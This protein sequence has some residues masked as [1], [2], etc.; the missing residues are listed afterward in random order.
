MDDDPPRRGRRAGTE[1]AARAQREGWLERTGQR[2][3]LG[4]RALALGG[5]A[6]VGTGTGAT[7]GTGAGGTVGTGTAGT[8]PSYINRF[9]A[10]STT[11]TTRLHPVRS[12]SSRATVRT[13]SSQAS[14]SDRLSSCDIAARTPPHP[15]W[16]Q[17]MTSSTFRTSIAYCAT[18][19]RLLSV[20]TTTFAML[21]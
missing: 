1:L 14:T 17:T 4:P 7:V 15:S 16:P 9:S 11:S 19:S 12:L 2:C 18:A 8:A 3:V 13:R 10:R 5:G 6:T 20:G 21:R